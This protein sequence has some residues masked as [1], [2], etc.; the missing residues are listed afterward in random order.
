VIESLTVIR[1]SFLRPVAVVIIVTIIEEI[2]LRVSSKLWLLNIIMMTLLLETQELSGVV[3]SV[4]VVYLAIG[5]EEKM[6]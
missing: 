2:G 5:V 4:M 1:I 3:S 6:I